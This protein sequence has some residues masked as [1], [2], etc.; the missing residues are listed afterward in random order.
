MKHYKNFF[1]YVVVIGVFSF[2]MYLIIGA[3][4]SLESGRGITIREIVGD[5][6]EEFIKSVI[7]NL[8][9][10]LALLL[11]QIVTI[12]VV[13]R[14]FGFIF[15]S[16]GQPTVIGEI[17][18]GIILGPTVVGYYFPGFSE[19]LFPAKSLG[20]LQ[21]LSQVGLIL[22]MFIVGMELDLKI[23]KNKAD[24]AV[25]VSHASIIIPFS[26]GMG[27]AY[28]I[29]ETFAPG[30]I[31]FS[32][33]SLFIGIAMSI[34]AFP[35]LA[36]IVQERG[37]HRTRLG[38]IVITCA[39][40]DDISAWFI[41]AIVIAIVKAGSFLSALYIIALAL[42]YLVIMIKVVRPFLQRIGELHA[43]RENL[44]KPI[45]AIFFMVLIASAYATEVIGIHALF[46]AFVAGVIMP[47]NVK[48]R[49]IFIEK[50]EDVSLV[51]LLPL[52]FVYT[53]LRTEIG[54][55]N[56]LFL[57]KIT[58]L[59]ILVAIVG[60][61]LGSALAARF[62]GQSWK[63][64]LTIGA[65]MNTRGLMELV[66]LNIGFDLGVLTPEVFTMMVIMALVTTFMTGP[67]LTFINKIFKGD[68]GGE[69][70]AKPILIGQ[71]V[72][73]LISFGNPET[74]RVLLRLAGNF[75]KKQEMSEVTA[76]HFSPSTEM[77]QYAIVQYEKESFGPVNNEANQMNRKIQTVFKVSNDFYKD[78]IDETNNGKY[79]LLLIGIGQSIYEGSALGRTIGYLNALFRRERF[80]KKVT[81]QERLFEYS[82]F[83][84]RNRYLFDG[85]NIPVGVFVNK[86]FTKCD[87]LLLSIQT[88][89]DIFTIDFAL[90]VFENTDCQ[91]TIYDP[92]KI[93]LSRQQQIQS[94]QRIMFL[95][96]EKVN[97]VTANGMKKEQLQKYDLLFVS[98]LGWKSMLDTES[99]WL[100]YSPSTLILKDKKAEIIR[101][102]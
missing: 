7:Y 83:E 31:Q 89:A 8:K 45:I 76:L 94:L 17:I 23:L 19:N 11:A 81:G 75:M 3:G 69:P 63:D 62:V 86:K 42:V 91:I 2:L 13:A 38:A 47:D 18:A 5:H 36:R 34:T 4:Q 90:L 21:L 57:W 51:L 50:V 28:F 92:N 82:A 100:N 22:F 97:I 74:G 33:F 6:W 84:E 60:K 64:S 40:V 71:V 46:G 79:N 12:I 41:L 85:S 26:L 53:G 24:D 96:A 54:L 32:S 59:I 68:A 27:L 98:V 56:E 43:S 72:R 61:F 93:I 39:A 99:L 52:F 15:K 9:H 80:I 49:S 1:F 95:N 67:A 30:G 14:F 25:V 87:N 44:T 37:I 10:P 101:K 77:N 29:Y 78:I 65:L 48:F 66:V 102:H 70:V 58:G 55:L 35:V 16:I 20:N 73:V 88:K